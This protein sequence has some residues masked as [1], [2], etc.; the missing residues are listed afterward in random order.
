MGYADYRALFT[1]PWAGP[2]GDAW[3]S[4]LGSLQ[5][6]QV[7]DAKLAVKARFPSLAPTDALPL[8]GQDRVIER[9][10]AETDA[11]YAARLKTAFDAW[12]WAG[13]ATGLQTY[14]LAPA[15]Y[16]NTRLISN[17]DWA[18]TFGGT[19]PD[20]A[21]SKWARFWVVVAQP[22]TYTARVWGTPPAANTFAYGSGLWGS[23]ASADDV[24]RLKRLLNTWKCARDVAM[25]VFV[26]F[27]TST[28]P[29]AVPASAPWIEDTLTFGGAKCNFWRFA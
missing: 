3:N 26:V 28:T 20:G 25:G 1:P 29:D 27:G 22:P 21:T 8:I 7:A 16:T 15:G 2:T 9:G 6:Q 18:G 23:N 14:V 10:P 5:D 12:R 13:T 19:P 24:T 11:D 17:R 4:A